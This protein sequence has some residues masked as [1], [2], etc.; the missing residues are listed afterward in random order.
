MGSIPAA[1]AALAAFK[2]FCRSPPFGAVWPDDHCTVKRTAPN[3]ADLARFIFAV[4]SPHF[5]ASSTAPTSS[6][7]PADATGT[8]P[9]TQIAI[10]A[11]ATTPVRLPLTRSPLV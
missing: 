8:P 9:N 10:S 5:A 2:V 7:D 4:G 3:P 11:V 1:R 6:G